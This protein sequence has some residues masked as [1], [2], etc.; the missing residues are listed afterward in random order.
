MFLGFSTLVTRTSKEDNVALEQILY[1][2]YLIR[3][4]KNKV[5]ALINLNNEVNAIT[6]VYVSKLG[7]QIYHTNVEAQMINNFTFEIFGIV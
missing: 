5:Q 7:L 2:Y 4:K 3:F 1:I 6:P